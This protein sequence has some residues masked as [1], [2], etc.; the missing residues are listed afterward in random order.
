MTSPSSGGSGLLS[1]RQR[2]TWAGQFRWPGSE[3]LVEVQTSSVIVAKQGEANTKQ[4]IPHWSSTQTQS[5]VIINTKNQLGVKLVNVCHNY[6]M[7][8]LS[9]F[10]LHCTQ[11]VFLL[12]T[13]PP[14]LGFSSFPK[15]YSNVDD[16][17]RLCCL[18]ESGQRLEN[19]D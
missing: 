18:E 16:I 9:T 1:R 13:Q 3:I 14:R 19:V 4:N 11:V 10:G 15:M 17:Y 6:H 7:A 5:C 2:P 12:F 8:K